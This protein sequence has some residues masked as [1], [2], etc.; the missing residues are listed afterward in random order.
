MRASSWRSE[1]AA[2][3]RGLASVRSPRSRARSLKAS[4]PARG[5]Y[6][7]PRTSSN[8]GGSPFYNRGFDLYQDTSYEVKSIDAFTCSL[9]RGSTTNPLFLLNHWIENPLPAEFLS[10]MANTKD[11]LLGR[12][13]KC[14]AE[15]GK[16]PNFVAVNHY[17]VGSLFEVVQALNGL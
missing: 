14:Q 16:L 7:S 11:V 4:N 9:N 15:S 1:P 8:G 6:T 2:P 17:S 12:A 13:R 3:L 5:M 10:A